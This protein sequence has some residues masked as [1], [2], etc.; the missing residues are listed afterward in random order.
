MNRTSCKQEDETSAAALTGTLGPEIVSHAKRCPV[1]SD[2]LLVA[3]LLNNHSSTNLERTAPPDPGLIWQQARSQA[4]QES[5]RVAL[6]PIRFMTIVAILAFACSPWLRFMLPMS[7]EFS[8]S[9]SRTLDSTAA[10]VSKIS[11]S[12]PTET[13]L[14]LGFAATT[15][16]L[17]LSSWY[18]LRQE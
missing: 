12:P 15:V 17:A 18:L 5:L 11:L 6:R 4:R 14:L 8:A 13:T 3:G 1:C 10:F 16:L 2:I 9:W 7:K